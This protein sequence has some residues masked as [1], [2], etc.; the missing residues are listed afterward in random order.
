MSQYMLSSGKE[1]TYS[2]LA[3]R[4]IVSYSIHN[5]NEQVN[6]FFLPASISEVK[7]LIKA[8]EN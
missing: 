7:L 4:D 6:F 1:G 2:V 5:K 3:C 8:K